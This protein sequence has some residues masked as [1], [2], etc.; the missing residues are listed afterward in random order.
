MNTKPLAY[1]L[2]PE[3]LDDIIGQ[4]HLV[5]EKESFVSALKKELSFHLFSLDLQALVRLH[6]L[7]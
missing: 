2:R 6:L 5:G 7:K 4:Q 1:R 3:S